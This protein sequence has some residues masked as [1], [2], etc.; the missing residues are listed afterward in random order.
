MPHGLKHS[1]AARRT[2]SVGSVGVLLLAVA[3]ACLRANAAAMPTLTTARAVH[4]MTNEEAARRYPVHL[5]DACVLYYNPDIGNLFIRDSSGSVYV[6]MRGQPRL[7]LRAGDLLEIAGIS[8]A[9]GFAPLVS[10]PVIRLTGHQPLPRAPRVSIDHLL[11]GVADTIWVEVQGI[12][13]SVVESDHLT[14][15]VDQGASG[16][17]NILVTIATGAGRLDVITM[18]SGGIDYH[19]LVDSD[20]VVRG[21]CGPRFNKKGQL[22]GVHLFTPSL[23]EVR[24]VTQGPKDPFSLPIREVGTVMQYAPDAVPGHR[25]RVRGVVTSHWGGRWISIMDHGHGMV[26]QSPDAS[27]FAIGDLIDVAGFPGISGYTATLEDVEC[28]RI[29]RQAPP[30]ARVITAADAFKGDPDSELVRIRGRLLGQTMAPDEWTLLLS[31]GRRAFTALLPASA[32]GSSAA[33]LRD[34]STLELTGICS[35]EV[36]PDKTPKAVRILLRSPADIAVLDQPSWWTAPRILIVLGISLGIILL[37]GL[38]VIVL[39]GQV[40][41]RTEALRATLESTADGI[42]VVDSAGKVVA[43]NGKFAEMWGI[44]RSAFDP[45]DD[46]RLLNSVLPQLSDPDAFLSRVREIHA[47]P[48]SHTDDAV[49]LK[50]GRIFER[51][52]EPQHIRGKNIGRVWGFRDVTTGRKLQARLDEERHLLHQ[53]M[54]NL[55]DHIYFKDRESRFGLVNRSHVAGFGCR[56]AS[57]L[58]GKTDFD[59]FT[60]EHAQPAWD[61]EHDLIHERTPVVSKEEKETWADGRETWVLTTKLP[62]RDA[63]GRIIG[64]FGVSRDITDRKRIE[65]EL[66][67]AKKAAEDASHAKSEFLANMSHE[68]RTPMNGILGMTELALETEL[69]PEQREYLGMVHSS[70][71]SL[72]TII[73]D[74]LD[75]SK[76]EAG[77]LEMDRIEFDL[78]DSLEETARALALRAAD[79][80]LELICDIRPEVPAIVAGD[81][82]RLRQVIVNLLSNAIKFT[83]SGEVAL[84]VEVQAIDGDHATLLFTVRDTGIGIP[85]EKRK[86]IF[87]AFAQADASTTRMFGGTGLG[88]SIASRLVEMM[89]GRIWVE[90][91]LGKGSRF[92]FTAQLEIVRRSAEW[93]PSADESKLRGLPV[94][95]VDDNATNRRLLGDILANWE[96]HPVFAASVEE[97]LE[98]LYRENGAGSAIPLVLSDVF[99]PGEDGF[100]LVARIRND[101]ELSAT[102]IIML[103]SGGRRGDTARCREL[104]VSGYLM[105]PVRR[106]ELR[107]AILAALGGNGCAPRHDEPTTWASSAVS[108]RSLRVLVTEDN[109]VNQRLVLR[110]LEKLGHSAI[111]ACDGLQA[112]EAISREDID[113]VLMDVQMPEMDGFQATAAIRALEETTGTHHPIIAMT[114]HAMKGDHERCLAAGMDGYLSKPIQLHLLREILERVETNAGDRIPD[115]TER[116][117][118]ET[119]A[120]SLSLRR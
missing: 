89:G 98:I 82:I 115:V 38:W 105:K 23:T 93:T 8:G 116:G 90:S 47:D 13:R 68:I 85:H 7:S 118:P 81:P 20:V 44:P 59:F 84:T 45:R 87:E 21:V 86:L 14:A 100:V 12:V 25:I 4:S 91:A 80:N 43:W 22:I 92:R 79:K 72:L 102:S 103:A 60:L 120:H 110:F 41:T 11:T 70:A 24:V 65:S 76:I 26:L 64:T 10:R 36:L 39:R 32:S 6:D 88:L 35:V 42:L 48:E 31:A 55:P 113:L 71:E 94:L 63:A 107:T 106:S 117:H 61:D 108:H 1:A 67:A 30:P 46:G 27:R 104:G 51:H 29:G 77:R 99:L 56:D 9:G 3:A 109:V 50:D 2:Q 114:A 73:N 78:R 62:F 58:I 19:N 15:Y 97:A 17:G 53:L 95:V 66:S 119:R 83:S 112:V 111:L 49:D 28:R 18:E 16:K 74:I 40:D 33:S 52:S 57:D 54:D 69:L 37:S 101:P 5:H 75:F 34:G 96:L